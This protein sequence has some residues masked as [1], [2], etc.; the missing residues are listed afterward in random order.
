[1]IPVNLVGFII[2]SLIIAALFYGF[3]FMAGKGKK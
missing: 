1:V 2:Y 3:G